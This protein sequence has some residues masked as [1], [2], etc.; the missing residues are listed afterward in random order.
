MASCFTFLCSVAWCIIRLRLTSIPSCSLS[1]WP[2]HPPYYQ[3]YCHQPSH[4]FLFFPLTEKQRS[5]KGQCFQRC[6]GLSSWL[7]LSILTTR[8]KDCIQSVFKPVLRILLE[9]RG[10]R[11]QSLKMCFKVWLLRVKCPH[12]QMVHPCSFQMLK[13]IF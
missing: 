11:I 2:P 4:S 3:L 6:V 12:N 13:K 1:H 9:M 10:E 8:R 5:R 7:N